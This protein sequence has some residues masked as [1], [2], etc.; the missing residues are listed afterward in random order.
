MDT[1][2]GLMKESLRKI[3]K[4]REILISLT[5]NVSSIERELD[6]LHKDLKYLRGLRVT[7]EN[8]I[9]FLKK[10][11]IIALV[12][13]YREAIDQ[14]NK[15]DNNINYYES[16]VEK[17]SNNLNKY[18]VEFDKNMEEYDILLEIERREKVVLLFDPS[19]KRKKKEE[20]NQ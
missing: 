11:K 14:L 17:A 12:N 4:I 15:V 20:S 3:K 9:R 10:D 1:G 2:K 8:N 5:N 13:G 7:V 6:I 18:K 16:M 19:K